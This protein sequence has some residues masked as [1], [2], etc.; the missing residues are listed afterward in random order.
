MECC[1]THPWA[2]PAFPG[3]SEAT[4][5]AARRGLTLAAQRVATSCRCLR[6]ARCRQPAAA[7][8][9][10]V[11]G[12]GR[13]TRSAA[14]R[15]AEL[16]A[17][18]SARAVRRQV[19]E[20]ARPQIYSVLHQLLLN[21]RYPCP[22]PCLSCFIALPVPLSAPDMFTAAPPLI[23]AVSCC[24]GNGLKS[25]R[26]LEATLEM[27]SIA[28]TGDLHLHCRTSL[29]AAAECRQVCLCQ[30]TNPGFGG[31]PTPPGELHDNHA[32]G[33]LNGPAN[34]LRV[35]RQQPLALRPPS[36]PPAAQQAALQRHGA[37]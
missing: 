9:H 35:V 27:L 13:A 28:D 24:Q 31:L 26:A 14:E 12:G 21:K 7:S 15:G 36:A 29:E 18:R 22:C 6:P 5:A 25:L 20:H 19:P 37:G 17:V 11:C 10:R 32:L 16:R 23:E 33:P 34:R 2:A 30:S 3:A 4:A 8:W 1:P